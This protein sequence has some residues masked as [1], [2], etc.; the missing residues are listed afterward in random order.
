MMENNNI[1]ILIVEDEKPILEFINLNLKMSG[2]ETLEASTGEEALELIKKEHPNIVLLDIMLPGIDGFEVCK[3]IRQNMPE[4]AIIML[5]ARG[6]DIDKVMGLETGADDYI[7]KPFNPLE[8]IARIRALTRRMKIVNIMEHMPVSIGP[9]RLDNDTKNIYK[10]EAPLDLT[11]REYNLLKI[12]IEN[13]GKALSR[14]ELLNLAWGED[15]FGDTKTLDVHIRRLRE[16][17]E[18]SPSEPQYIITVW[19]YG[20]MWR[21]SNK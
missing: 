14:D 6:Q 19:G 8:L 20:Y 11:P 3:R 9:F 1:K 12:L 7:V 2:F 18:N 13:S 5:T 4:T 17:I 10:D 21:E 16:K 15:Y